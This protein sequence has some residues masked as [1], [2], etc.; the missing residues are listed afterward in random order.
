MFARNLQDRGVNAVASRQPVRAANRNYR[1]LWEERAAG[2]GQLIRER[3]A[4]RTSARALA[5]RAD[6]I[7]A[8]EK[9]AVA[10]AR[11][12]DPED[13][14]L[15]VEAIRYL[16][17]VAPGGQEAARLA[18]RAAKQHEDGRSK[19]HLAAPTSKLDRAR[20]PNR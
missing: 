5:V 12:R 15:A 16:G 9:I 17:E 6:A 13:V 11:S 3:P 4:Q 14:R 19:G 7:K 8:W 2:R 20:S 10:L 18:A 1:K